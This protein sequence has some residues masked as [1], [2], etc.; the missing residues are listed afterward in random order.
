MKT[1]RQNI[2]YNILYQILAIILPFITAPYLSRVIGASGVGLYSFSHSIALYFTYITL[3]GLT[4]YGNRMIASVQHDREKRSLMFC[5]IYAMQTICFLVSIVA[6]LIYVILFA[7]D[8]TA[9]L[10]MIFTVI[11]SLFDISWFYFGIENFKVTVIRNT[12]IKIISVILIFLFVKKKEDIYVYILIMSISFLASQLCLWPLIKK[13]VDFVKPKWNNILKHFKPNLVLFVPVIAVSIYKIIDKVILGFMSTMDQVGYFENAE[14]IITLATTLI[15]AVGT[16]M[17]P[18]MTSLFAINNRE[19]SNF[20]DKTMIVVLAYTNAV[21][22]GILAVADEFTLVYY[23]KEFMPTATIMK[24]LAIT[25][26]F[27]G[28]GNVIRTQYLIP[29]QEDF[30]YLKSAIIGAVINVCINF[31]LIPNFNAIGAAISTVFAEISVCIYQLYKVRKEV[32]LYLYLKWEVVFVF[33]GI[34][35][36]LLI[37][38]MPQSA[39]EIANL[40]LHIIVGGLTY[41]IISA[42][43]IF[44]VEKIKDRMSS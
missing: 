22:F 31:L 21:F 25:V 5:E 29:K 33:F 38:L 27:L 12:I 37:R 41:V 28:A 10:I 36:F 24:F 4:N 30:V 42:I 20:I 34:I 39:N 7:E 40:G 23:G 14:R 18:R 15:T 2:I 17:L 3:L 8:K 16:V 35:M 1:L 13:Y 19:S 9:S 43:Y 6:Y 26:I 11:S 44:K 32:H